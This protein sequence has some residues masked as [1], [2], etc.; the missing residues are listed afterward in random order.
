MCREVQSTSSK[1]LRS[2]ISAVKTSYRHHL[3][4]LI[5]SPFLLSTEYSRS[6][7]PSSSIHSTRDFTKVFFLFH[8]MEMMACDF[9]QH[10]KKERERS[11]CLLWPNNRKP[12]LRQLKNNLA[13]RAI[14]EP[15]GFIKCRRNSI[16]PSHF[17]SSFVDNTSRSTMA[18]PFSHAQVKHLRKKSRRRSRSLSLSRATTRQQDE[19][20]SSIRR[21]SSAGLN[22]Y[23]SAY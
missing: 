7:C 23:E 4:I 2:A 15:S 6:S 19:L 9:D 21:V 1:V 14:C 18:T 11:S 8:P 13:L 12:Y 10:E 3:S 5:C 22:A 20:G 17:I 16:I